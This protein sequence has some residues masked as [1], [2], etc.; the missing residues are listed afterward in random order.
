MGH[1]FPRRIRKAGGNPSRPLESPR[2]LRPERFTFEFQKPDGPERDSLHRSR[3]AD[4]SSLCHG[5]LARAFPNTNREGPHFAHP[6]RPTHR[7]LSSGARTTDRSSL[8]EYCRKTGLFRN[9]VEQGKGRAGG[10]RNL[11]S[12][13]H[14]ALNGPEISRQETRNLESCFGS[15][16]FS[17]EENALG[18]VETR[19]IN[20]NL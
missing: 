6:D 5:G 7:A 10:G 3:N 15:V 9:D 16:D 8:A 19:Q 4:L 11:P 1:G 13:A 17:R 12:G 18:S 20:A 2:R 14:R